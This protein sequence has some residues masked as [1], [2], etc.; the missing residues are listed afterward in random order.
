V[1][2][3]RLPFLFLSV[4]SLSSLLLSGALVATTSC[5]SDDSTGAQ[6]D[7][8]SSNGDATADSNASATDG[9][10]AADSSGNIPSDGATRCPRALGPAD[11]ARRVVASHPFDAMGNKATA[12][13]LLTLSAVGVLSRATP[14]VTFQ[15]GTALDSNIA[16]TPDGQVAMVAQD[17]G[18]VG[19]VRFD[20]AGPVVVHAA[21]KGSFYAG[22]VVMDPRGDRAYV[23]D[24]NTA[25]N[26]GGV[27]VV[28]IA[29]DG[30]LTDRGLLVPGGN[31]F[32]MAFG[33]DPSLQAV[34]SAAAAYDSDASADTHLV[35]FSDAG[36]R[37][38]SGG[39]FPEG[40]AI[41]SDI[42]IS[43]DG[44]LALL[45][46]DG[47]NVGNRVAIVDV[48]SLA[49]RGLISVLNPAAIVVAPSGSSGLLMSSD[50]ND[51]IHLLTFTGD[52]SAPVVLGPL[53][54][55]AHGKPQLPSFAQ[56]VTRGAL[57]G[58]V[59]VAENAAIREV[60]FLGDAGAQ[61]TALLDF[62]AATDAVVGVIGL[63]P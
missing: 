40:G 43:P 4:S 12:F 15:M 36:A 30:T 56:M 39:A 21:F 28:D 17:D 60:T 53:L 48:P 35:D 6:S 31:A 27:Y 62:G 50:G 46:D 32:A 51:A 33:P 37:V 57:K 24:E 26:K 58:L 16:F 47:I 42:A 23:L 18:T 2:A 61:D 29:C 45:A 10:A 54:S 34:L 13:E 63:A 38:A 3:P 44:K 8:S 14:P 59:L 5:G 7:A 52:A 49:P 9:A 55:Y 1:K 20:S 41:V 19:V 11:G 25:G 22:K